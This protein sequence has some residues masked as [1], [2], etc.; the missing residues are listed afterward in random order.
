MVTTAPTTANASTAKK[1]PASASAPDL[2]R[3]TATEDIL[4]DV[5]SRLLAMAPQF[6]A[7]VAKQMEAD[8]RAAWGG[9]RVYVPNKRGQGRSDRNDAIRRDFYRNGD[10]IHLLTRRY[11]LTRVQIWRILNQPITDQPGQPA[12]Q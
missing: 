5:F 1:A 4:E 11:K 12:P 2:S 10:H 8:L 3:F 7:A 6:N 9:Q